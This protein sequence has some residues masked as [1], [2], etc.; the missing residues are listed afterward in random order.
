M[1][2]I[3]PRTVMLLAGL[4]GGLMSLV[5]F[6][7]R[8]NY[9]RT[10]HGLGE[11]TSAM[12]ILFVAGIVTAFRGP[13]PDA[14]AVMLIN[15][16]L[17]G[18][19]YLLFV[20]SQRF[21]GQASAVRT[22]S[23]ALGVVCAV[24]LWFTV[25]EPSYRWRL[26]ILTGVLGYLFGA[27]AWLLLRQPRKTSSLVFVATVLCCAAAIQLLRFGLT[28][29]AILGDGLTAKLP[30]GVGYAMVYPIVFLLVSIGLM[31][32]AT[33][34]LR[35]EM[36]HLATHDALTHA[37]TRRHLSQS[38][39]QV[40]A[41]SRRHGR[42]FSVLAMDLDH[43]KAIND[44]YGHQAGDRV[45]VDFVANAK[46][47]L[48]AGDALGRFGGEEF[49]ALLPDTALPEALRIAERI[50]QQCASAA[51]SPSCTVSI[52][53]A[54]Y[55][56]DSATA[57]HVLARA[58]AALYRAKANGRNRIESDGDRTESSPSLGPSPA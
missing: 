39:E 43:F 54:S 44:Q 49:V 19:T 31:L 36:E 25:M 24:L 4:M 18:G 51:T 12:L 32:L 26:L 46:A 30:Q 2:A 15:L 37:L 34:R 28:A 56:A 29:Q 21:F 11:W 8:R 20:G 14:V 48:R 10:I 22:H 13:I 27:H 52:G 57:A 53:V 9:P 6:F 45:L 40:F 7:L 41:Q 23:A 5:M 50:C 1:N 35:Q 55:Q 42:S 17:L 47:L 38:C 3:D 16:L 33:D 58:D